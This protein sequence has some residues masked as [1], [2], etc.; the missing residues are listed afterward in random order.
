MQG[1]ESKG[2]EDDSIKEEEKWL[3]AITEEARGEMKEDS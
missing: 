2:E 1:G 3:R